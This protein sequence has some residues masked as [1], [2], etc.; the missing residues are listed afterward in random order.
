V[1]Q[2]RQQAEDVAASHAGDATLLS[3]NSVAG[4]EPD[5]AERV[6]SPLKLEVPAASASMPGGSLTPKKR[7]GCRGPA[8]HVLPVVPRSQ[9]GWVFKTMGM[10]YAARCMLESTEVTEAG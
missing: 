5:A 2:V 4:A 1:L 9:V 8:W 6:S 3:T 10:G 7:I